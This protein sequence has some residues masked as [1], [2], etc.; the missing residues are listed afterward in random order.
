VLSINTWLKP[1]QGSHDNRIR[2][3]GY[4]KMAP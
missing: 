3:E 4:W 1:D 2:T